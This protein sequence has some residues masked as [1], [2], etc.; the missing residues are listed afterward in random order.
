MNLHYRPESTQFK[1]RVKF[2]AVIIQGWTPPCGDFCENWISV[3]IPAGVVNQGANTL[4]LSAECCD[5]VS[6]FN[7]SVITLEEVLVD[8]TLD[9]DLSYVEDTL[10]IDFLLGTGQ[11]AFWN[12]WLVVPNTAVRL[13]SAPIP[14][15]DPA[16]P[17]PV[18]IPGFPP[19]GKI[20]VLTWLADLDGI[21]CWTFATVDTGKSAETSPSA[22]ELRNLLPA[23]NGLPRRN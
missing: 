3:P 1:V 15:I 19:M 18:P 2:N 22:E 5:V 7:D 4:E 11:P 8:C 9:V 17:F 21:K 20:A 14:V 16:E 12:V 13:W 10:N 23:S 6:L